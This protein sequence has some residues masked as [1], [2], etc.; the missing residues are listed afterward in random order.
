MAEKKKIS[1]A[2]KSPRLMPEKMADPAPRYPSLY[3]IRVGDDSP[4][5]ARELG[6]DF[7][8][9]ATMRIVGVHKTGSGENSLELEVREI[10]LD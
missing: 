3:G 5:L 2:Q 9:D 10:E 1:L 8:G 4:L 7:R 6:K